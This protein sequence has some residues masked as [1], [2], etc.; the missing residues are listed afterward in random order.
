M[1]GK[2]DTP[3]AILNRQ[4][5]EANY[6]R[7]FGKPTDSGRVQTAANR[8]PVTKTDPFAGISDDELMQFGTFLNAKADEMRARKKPL[9]RGGIVE[10]R[11]EGLVCYVPVNTPSRG[12]RMCSCSK[13]TLREECE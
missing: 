8:N 12:M 9:A 10:A 13:K 1:S 4:R 3:R 7:I 11:E 5:Y 6:D 2:G